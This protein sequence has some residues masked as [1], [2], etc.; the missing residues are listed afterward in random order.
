MLKISETAYNNWPHCVEL[1]NEKIKL[2]VTTDVGPRIIYCGTTDSDFNLF[3]Q[4]ENQGKVNSSEWLIYGGHRLWHSPQIG[5]RPNQSD[6]AQ[7][8]YTVKDHSLVLNCPEETATKVQKEIIITLDP[9]KARVQVVHRIYN[10]G[11]WPIKLAAWALTVMAEGGTVILPIPRED[12]WFMPNYA[13]SFWPWTK[14]ND[15]RF[16]LGERYMLLKHDRSDERWFKIGYRNTEGWG[17]YLINGF[18][19]VK[20]YLPIPGEEYPDYG[21][22][23]E[24]YADNRFLELESLGPLKTLEPGGFTEHKEEWYVF[25]NVNLP[26]SESDISESKILEPKIDENAANLISMINHK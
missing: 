17:A 19:F 22:T 8:P 26:F 1:K 25:E 5:F 16:T 10:R 24:I 9:D 2:I 21:S 20:L 23:F 12:T 3:Y 14:P 6:N 11:L 13:I 18:M 4:D 7:V 15:H